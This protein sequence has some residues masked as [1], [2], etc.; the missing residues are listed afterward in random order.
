MPVNLD[1]NVPNKQVSRILSMNREND[2]IAMLLDGKRQ[3]DIVT[4]VVN[5]YHVEAG[6]VIHSLIPQA[7]KIIKERNKYEL[8]TMLSLHIA[9][10][11]YIYEKLYEMGAMT[12]AMRAL[13][14]KE[15]LLGFHR[16]GFH[17]RVTE[18]EISSISLQEINT[19]YD[20]M[21]LSKERRDRMTELVN[22]MAED[23]KEKRE[24]ERIR[25]KGLYERR[26]LKNKKIKKRL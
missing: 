4:Y 1:I 7:R 23:I 11:E 12:I 18:G 19:E 26:K 3:K 9:R 8:S 25:Q 16:E 21:R 2:I 24:M 14:S 10:Y 6:Y 17:L 5:K 22:K 20:V 13:V 15:K